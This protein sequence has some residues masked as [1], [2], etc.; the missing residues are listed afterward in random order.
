MVIAGL[1][2][3]IAT[4]KSTVSRFLR[5]L[6]AHIVDADRIARDVVCCGQ[7]AWEEIKEQFGEEI[8]LDNGEIDRTKLGRIVFYDEGKRA[9]LERIIHPEVSRVM[10]DEVREITS[11][12]PIAVVILDVPLLI[13]ITMDRGLNQVIVV[14]CPEDIQIQRLMERDQINREDAMARVRAQIPIEEKKLHA[15]ILI[16]NSFSLDETRKQVEQAYKRLKQ[17]AGFKKP[18]NSY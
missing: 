1:T 18:N 5:E 2:G 11:K 15:T 9:A 14:Y 13:E 12:D 17:K 3:G 10:E 7:P 8:L 4:G 6:G 16:D